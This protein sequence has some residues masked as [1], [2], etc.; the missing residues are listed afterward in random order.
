MSGLWPLLIFVVCL[1]TGLSLGCV[2]LWRAFGLT[3]LLLSLVCYAVAGFA[4]DIAC[5]I[6]FY[7]YGTLASKPVKPPP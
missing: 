4:A 5:G 7:T 1:F 6:I 2:A 3:G